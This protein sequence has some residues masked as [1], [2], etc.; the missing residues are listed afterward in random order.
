MKN[1]KTK[2]I[3]KITSMEDKGDIRVTGHLQENK[4]RMC[5]KIQLR[6]FQ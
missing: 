2:A 4:E 5:S 1:K 3:Q 6:Q